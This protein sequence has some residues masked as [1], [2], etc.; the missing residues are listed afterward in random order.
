MLDGFAPD[1]AR[2]RKRGMT[3]GGQVHGDCEDGWERCS[4][5]EDLY[6][7]DVLVHHVGSVDDVAA[8]TWFFDYDADTIW[9]GDGPAGH[10]VE[11][12]DTR[13][14]RSRPRPPT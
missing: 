13:A 4:Y 3:Q 11:L 6:V 10:V 12:T 1:G 7:D 9:L 2:W 8:G 5:P 14:P